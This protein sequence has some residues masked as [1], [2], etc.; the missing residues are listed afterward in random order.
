METYNNVK[1]ASIATFLDSQGKILP[2]FIKSNDN[3]VDIKTRIQRET[4]VDIKNQKL[5]AGNV[6]SNIHM[7]NPRLKQEWFSPTS[8]QPIKSRKYFILR[9]ISGL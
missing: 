9:D 5:V 8:Y 6:S 7:M 1:G 4:G 2:I 3:L